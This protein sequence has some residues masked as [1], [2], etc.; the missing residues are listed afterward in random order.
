AHAPLASVLLIH[1]YDPEQSFWMLFQVCSVYLPGYYTNDLFGYW[2]DSKVFAIYMKSYAKKASQMLY[3]IDLPDSFLIEWLMC[4]YTRTFTF[5]NSMRIFD[6][7]LCC[8]SKIL[9]RIGYALLEAL[10]ELK[11][12]NAD[13]F[14]GLLRRLKN[15][16]DLLD[17]DKIISKAQKM[18]SLSNAK[19]R[20]GRKHVNKQK[21]RYQ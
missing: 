14:F 8:G 11:P 3:E 16:P 18:T 5:Q 20:K 4:A 7:F 19:I 17:I 12:T 21:G 10:A 1:T 15:E 13:Q 2:T 6:L 9:F